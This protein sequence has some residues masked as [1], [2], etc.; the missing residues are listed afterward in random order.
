MPLKSYPLYGL[1]K[2]VMVDARGSP[3][4]F[5][6]VRLETQLILKFLG[7]KAGTFNAS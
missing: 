6:L 1:G 4:V 7:E 5:V 2:I 3:L